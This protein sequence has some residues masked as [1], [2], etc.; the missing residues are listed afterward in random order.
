MAA[1]VVMILPPI[2]LY[3]LAQ[4]VFTQGVVFTGIKG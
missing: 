1:S 2:L 3:F 4:R